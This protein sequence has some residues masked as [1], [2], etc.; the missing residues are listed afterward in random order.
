MMYILAVIL[1]V[2]MIVLIILV[3]RLGIGR[4][5]K[6]DIERIIERNKENNNNISEKIKLIDS[7]MTEKMSIIEDNMADRQEDMRKAISASFSQQEQRFSSFSRENEQKLENIRETVQK[8]LVRMQEDNNRKLDEMRGVVDRNLQETL[9]KKMNESFSTVSKRLEEVHRGLGDMQNL[10]KDVGGLKNVL[11]NVKTRGILGEIQ[12]GAILKEILAPEQYEENVVVVPKSRKP[13][14][15]AIRLPGNDDGCVYLPIDS[16]FPGDRYQALLDAYDTGDKAEVEK[17]FKEL[18]TAILSEAK[19][20]KEK[21]ISPPYTTNFAIMFLPFEGLYS[22]VV[23][24]G[25]IEELQNK[26]NIN[27]AGPGTMAALLNSLQMGF[28]T[29][30]LQKRSTEVWNILTEV[31]TEFEKFAGILE[32]THDHL[33]RAE[34]SLDELMK[35]RTNQMMRK[36][37]KADRQSDGEAEVKDEE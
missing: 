7:N 2:L 26:F 4:I 11:S 3:V 21:Y 13:V 35:T 22:E 1:I 36:L 16:K 9:E 29:L 33:T 23:N 8:N 10:A 27:V 20:I 37:R 30:A 18:R 25:L 17:K 28:K 14:E 31:R 15:F 24:R 6:N 19:D 34:N 12:L 32:K 5:S